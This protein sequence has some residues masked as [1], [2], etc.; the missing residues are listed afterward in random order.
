MYVCE[1]VSERDYDSCIYSIK[2]AFH[3]VINIII[4]AFYAIWKFITESIFFLR[5]FFY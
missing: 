3:A 4:T 1:R 5:P 2:I